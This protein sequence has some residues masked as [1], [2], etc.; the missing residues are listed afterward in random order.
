MPGA[1]QPS[2][3]FAAMADALAAQ[4]ALAFDYDALIDVVTKEGQKLTLASSG[5][6]ALQ[7]PCRFSATR[8]GGF[9][10]IEADGD[11]DTLTLANPD[12]RFYSE[13][14]TS[15]G[16]EGLVAAL[17]QSGTT[18]LPAADLF[19]SAASAMAPSAW[20]AQDLGAGVV[21]GRI[22]DHLAFRGARAD[23]QIW[24]AQG[25]APL[26]RRLV[27]TDPATPGLLQY[28]VDFRNWRTGAE[29]AQALKPATRDGATRVPLA[30]LPDAGDLPEIYSLA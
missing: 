2:T 25:E 12:C 16:A 26:P 6:V 15:G 5:S 18:L 21:G 27:V 7:R 28:M 8:V 23:W 20:A 24:I 9:G 22:C 13:I 10:T 29:A 1:D 19:L 4:Q 11:G 30:E 14:A 3:L 17:R